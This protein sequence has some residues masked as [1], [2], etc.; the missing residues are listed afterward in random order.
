M[1]RVRIDKKFFKKLICSEPRTHEKALLAL[2]KLMTQPE[3]KG[4]NL[5]PVRGQ[6]G[7]YTIRMGSG[8][9]ILLRKKLDRKGSF[10]LAIEF[11]THNETYGS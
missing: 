9:R 7:L 4:L 10:Y 5:E 2:A 8:D 1:E 3:A 11:G 6:P